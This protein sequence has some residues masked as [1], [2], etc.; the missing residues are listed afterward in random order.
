MKKTL[1]ILFSVLFFC[2]FSP[3]VFSQKKNSYFISAFKSIDS[4]ALNTNPKEASLILDKVIE[5]A[6]AEQNT[7]MLIKGLLHRMLFTGYL[8][9]VA[10][11]KIN[12]ELKQ[13][14]ATARQPAK[15][16]LQSL[17]AESYWK[18][19]EQNRYQ[20]MSRTNVESNL[21]DDIK[22]WPASKFLE[23]TAKN[24]LASVSET[25]ILQGVKI[26]SLTE[27]MVG[28]EQS[29]FLRPT[30][31][32][33]LAHRALD[34]LMNTQIQLAN[35]DDAVNFN[36]Q[37]LFNDYE[38]FVAVVMPQTDSTSF[39]AKA[40]LIFQ[41]LIK[42]H[43]NDQ[44]ISALA[45][46]DL[47]RLNYVYSRSTSENKMNLYSAA[48][49]KL[50]ESS[51]SIEIYADI[52]FEL[53]SKKYELRNHQD[54]KQRPDLKLLIQMA[55]SVIKKYPQS[56]GGQNFE[57][58]VNDINYKTLSINI[59]QFVVQGKPTQLHFNYKNVNAISVQLYKL[60]Q[61][62][63]RFYLK[64]TSAYEN[65]IATNKIYKEWKINLP[66]HDDYQQHSIVDKLDG[67]EKGQYI[68]IAS[69]ADGTA[70]FNYVT[71]Q[72]TGLAVTNRI[73]DILNHQYIVSNSETG[74][75]IVDA[76]INEGN[77][78][79]ENGKSVY[80]DL[81]TLH[82]DKDGFAESSLN[83]AVS[84]IE[85]IHGGDTVVKDVNNRFYKYMATKS[86]VVLFTDRAIYRPGQTIFYKGI[87][88]EF[89]NEKNRILKEQNVDIT[90]NDANRKEIEKASKITN[91]FGTFQGSFII[92]LGKLNGRMSINT[93]YGSIDVQVEEY[94]RPTFEIVF[95]ELNKKYKLND[96]VT[97][98]GKAITFAGYSVPGAKVK[99]V[100]TRS[101]IATND[102]IYGYNSSKQIAMGT[103]VTKAGGVFDIRFMASAA[104]DNINA[105][106]Y[107]INVDITD[108]NGETI[109][110]SQIVNA[111][112]SD[113]LLN[114][115]LPATIFPS[116]LNNNITFEI[117]NLNKVP[118][119]G[120]LNVEWYKL[121]N[122]GRVVYS[123][124]L[125]K[126]EEYNLTKEEF[127]KQ[128][129]NQ[130]Y[131][132]DGNP[133]SWPAK[134]MNFVQKESVESGLGNLNLKANQLTSGYYKVKFKALNE[135]LDS[136]IV[137]KVVRIYASNS[138]KILLAKE[139]LVAEKTEITPTETA[140]FRFASVLPGAR[141][142][143]EVLYKDQIIKKVWLRLSNKQ[144]AINIKPEKYFV[145]DF[146]VQ[147]T[148][149]QKRQDPTIDE[150]G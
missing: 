137:E 31:Y 136:V 112:K 96:S 20:L 24:Y 77:Y 99:Y 66:A 109:T 74:E 21:G 148:L 71:F 64:D 49:G 141:A 98:K 30:L 62:S 103:T 2:S 94:K 56:L 15:S 55:N 9:E 146:G 63:N 61:I 116:T 13:D 115:D 143:Y 45:D 1:H 145:D 113:V 134:Q 18:Y 149:V 12:Q 81:G 69:I 86:K 144:T 25:Q 60:N 108:I 68:I 72:V 88:F 65:F 59:N 75:A 93:T 37:R 54:P 67:L 83:T 80:K 129:P 120:K 130:S 111:G 84:R 127:L 150:C 26:D 6:R 100:I 128:F 22:T 91:E 122:P 147:F 42:S 51:K 48:I 10:F 123:S 73:T 121:E 102:R 82:T 87:Y 114:I 53:A 95:E 117:T 58:L 41:N 40:L 19:Y 14:V 34:V 17:L 125:G 106:A 90:F 118:I 132:D 97:L 89:E 8:K 43:L 28:E 11:V 138:E 135:N 5:T 126:P 44:D 4:L 27:M 50:A 105:Y 47:K 78:K 142:Y 70:N 46:A 33:V 110:K 23:E 92:P 16:I 3:A 7:V 119:K 52:L 29:R 35:S 57:G 140:V 107:K 104:N 36:D 133:E 85:V 124:D 79:Y 101:V 139:W 131:A 39:S 32:D 76:I 38:S